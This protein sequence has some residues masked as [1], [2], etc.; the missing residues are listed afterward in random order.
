MILSFASDAR[1]F[2]PGSANA[3]GKKKTGNTIRDGVGKIGRRPIFFRFSYKRDQKNLEIDRQ[4]EHT[5]TVQCVAH[6][7]GYLSSKK[8]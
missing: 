6:I 7:T 3:L 4:S 2:P 8:R 1:T 5:V